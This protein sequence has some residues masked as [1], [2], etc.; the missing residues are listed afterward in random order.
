M[1]GIQPIDST[2]TDRGRVDEH[3][4]F[5]V[6]VLSRRHSTPGQVLFQSDVA[7][8]ETLSIRR[9]ERVRDL[10]RDWVHAEELVEIEMSTAQWGAL[11]SS[12]GMGSGISADRLP[13][14]PEI[15]A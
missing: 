14:I 8:Q 6:A 5:G 9:A 4:A 1:R 11:V 13:S 7:H 3:P 2:E 10:K 12:I 15:E